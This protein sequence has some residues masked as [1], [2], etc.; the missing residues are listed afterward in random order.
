MESS[1]R[2]Q[3][4]VACSSGESASNNSFPSVIGNPSA[5]IV[6]LTMGLRS[7]MASSNLNRVP[8]PILSGARNTVAAAISGRT[9]GTELVT[10]ILGLSPRRYIDGTGV[11]PTTTNVASE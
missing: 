3:I 5:P 2:E 1:I 7:A 10:L 8:P 9:S 6:V 11:L 4:A